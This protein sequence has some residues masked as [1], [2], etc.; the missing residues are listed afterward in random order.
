VTHRVSGRR[1]RDVNASA[2]RPGPLTRRVDG[3]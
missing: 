2:R 1:R 3:V